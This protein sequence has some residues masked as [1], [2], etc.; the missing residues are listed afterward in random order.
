MLDLTIEMGVPIPPDEPYVDLKTKAKAA[1]ESLKLLEEHGM[2]VLKSTPEDETVAAQ[3]VAAYA[4][5]PVKASQAANAAN[6]SLLTPPALRNLRT[7]LD[8]FGQSVVQNAAEVR[9]LV[10]NRLLEESQNPDPRIRIRA[11]E[12]LGKI[13]DVGLFTEKQEVTITHQ[14]TDELR[15]RLRGKL[16]RLIRK[17]EI[18]PLGDDVIDVGAEL[19]VDDMRPEDP[20][21]Y[22]PE[23]GNFDD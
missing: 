19:G 14:T 17:D 13:S 9:H 2:E 8:A 7:Y 12:L 11:L 5:D 1:C 16:Q 21:I 20:P 23:A 15:N 18:V 3:L 10:T 4:S 22:V 6:L